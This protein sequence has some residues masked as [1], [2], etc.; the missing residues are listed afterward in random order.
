MPDIVQGQ[1]F[2]TLKDFKKALTDWAIE[3]N[4]TPAILDSDNLRVRAGCRY[5]PFLPFSHSTHILI[6]HQI[7]SGLHIQDPMHL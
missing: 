7:G 6:C 3:K 2:P 4:F 1:E 5:G